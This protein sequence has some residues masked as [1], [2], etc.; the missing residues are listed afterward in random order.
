MNIVSTGRS[1][2]LSEFPDLQTKFTYQHANNEKTDFLFSQKRLLLEVNEKSGLEFL[3]IKDSTNQ[4]PDITRIKKIKIDNLVCIACP[5]QGNEEVAL[6]LSNGQIQL[7]N[8]KDTEFVHKFPADNSRNSVISLDYNASDEYISSVY[9]N[10]KINIYGTKTKTKLQT[11]NLDHN[12]TL[13]RFHPTKRF[14]LSI[15][16]YKGSVYIYDIQAKRT[17]FTSQEC[18]AAPCRDLCMSPALPD[19]LLSVGY[20]CIINV[21]DTRKKSKPQ[22]IQYCHPLST[23]AL[24]ECGNY[25]CV[26]NLKGELISYD[27]RNTKNYLAA[28]IVHDC[29]VTRIAFVPNEVESGTSFTT[30]GNQTNLDPTHYDARKS[31]ANAELMAKGRRDSFCDFLDFQAYRGNEKVSSRLTT[32]Q[33]DSFDWDALNKKTLHEDFRM[34]IVPSINQPNCTNSSESPNPG[35]SFEQSPTSGKENLPSP[36]RCESLQIPSLLHRR[37]DLSALRDR[38]NTDQKL[39]KIQEENEFDIISGNGS[40]EKDGEVMNISQKD[41]DGGCFL[42]LKDDQKSTPN[43]FKTASSEGFNKLINSK[44]PQNLDVLQEIQNIRIEMEERFT[45]LESELK[46]NAETNKWH[47]FTQ[48]CNL[49]N[50][51]MNCSEEIKTSLGILLQTDPFVNEYLRMK[52]ENQMLKNKLLQLGQH[53]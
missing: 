37:E 41:I 29:P 28:K 38:S 7:L 22:Q 3:R 32:R 23:V 11:L 26:G 36:S 31:L 47:I 4:K 19:V 1:T 5:K 46:F 45:Q 35:S 44:P 51:Q 8:Y 18:H 33:R 16:S 20:D 53:I 39:N 30:T 12:S 48:N 40:A 42:K 21:F 24:S 10:G 52:E 14:H 34:S 25:F 17:I 15:A 13:C 27:M 50:K 2:I 9:E 49:W 43:N 6:G